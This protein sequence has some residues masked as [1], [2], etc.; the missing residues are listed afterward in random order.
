MLGPPDASSF[1]TG[2]PVGCFGL[3]LGCGEFVVNIAPASAATTIV[4]PADGVITSW[5]LVGTA[6]G[7]VSFDLQVAHPA[8]GGGFLLAGTTPNATSVPVTGASGGSVPIGVGDRLAAAFTCFGN[9][10]NADVAS[11]AAPA[12]SYAVDFGALNA[13]TPKTPMVVPA[14]EMGYNATVALDAPQVTSLSPAAGDVGGGTPVVVSGEHLAVTTSVTVDGVPVT[15]SPVADG[16]EKFVITMP[17]HAA[18]NASLAVTTAG[19]TAR[20]PT[21]TRPRRRPRR[22]PRAPQPLHRPCRRPRPAD[23]AAPVISQLSISPSVFPAAKSGAAFKAA[24]TP[25]GRVVYRLSEPARS[26]FTVQRRS[27]G[28]RRGKSC[29][30]R[31]KHAHGGKCARSVAVKGS[32]SRSDVAAGLQTLRFTGHFNG[33]RLAVGHYTLTLVATDAAGNRSTP[34]AVAFSVKR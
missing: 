13:T 8:P 6:L 14:V 18:G 19:G 27:A 30:A 5:N 17:P 4:A 15:A 20:R 10:C 9:G 16:N 28:V 3:M 25:G 26:A 31:S 33:H 1:S 34:H 24:A 2:S 32:F 21:R 12:A 11:R 23:R 7:T 22:P 29:V